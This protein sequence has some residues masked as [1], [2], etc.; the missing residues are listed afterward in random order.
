[1][2]EPLLPSEVK[3]LWFTI[4]RRYVL[5]NYG[6]DALDEL[7]AHMGPEHGLVVTSALPSEWYPE[8]TLQHTLAAM[9]AVLARKNPV[10]F[11]RIIEEASL[12]GIH[13]FFRALLR[14]VPPGMML[15]KIPTM[16]SIMRRGSGHVEV[17]TG[18]NTGV[19]QYSRFPYF[20]DTLYRL[21]TKGAIQSMM[22]L[23]G[24]PEA[25]VDLVK[26]TTDTLTVE[27]RWP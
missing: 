8:A 3:G 20:D 27:V 18:D 19:V 17:E 5:E 1:M 7:T 26:H 22:T 13:H 6:Q 24:T 2:T 15:R 23:C 4:G 14:I 9:N 11:V 21:L 12:L 10:E 16:W 25:Q